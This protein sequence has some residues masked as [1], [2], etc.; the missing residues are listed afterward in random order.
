MIAD[1]VGPWDWQAHP[2]VWFLVAAVVVLGWWAARVIGPKVVPAGTPVTTPF[3]RRAFVAATILLLVSADWPMHD[4]AEDHLYS[5]HML[6]H[7]LITF[8]VPPLFLLAMPGWLA[9][10]LILEDGFGARILRRLT[11]PV[12]AGLIFNGL[13]ALTHWS[14]VVNWSA[15]FGAFHYGVHV[16]LFAA[17]LAM[18]MPVVAPLP[19]LRLSPPGQMLYLFLM[20]IIPTIPAAW[21]TFADGV[22]YPSYD[23]GFELW[24]VSVRSDQQ[25]A[26]LIMKLLGGFYIWGIIVVK[27]F[28]F[29]REQNRQNQRLRPAAGRL[30]DGRSAPV[31]PPQVTEPVE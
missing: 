12:V 22:V 10:L 27:F 14:S 1:V 13:V 7:L 15:E 19:E 21:L 30:P 6:Q 11:H 29:T 23:D 17:A 20:S 9:R 28:S 16:V 5:V 3:Q 8:I 26:G 31:E 18:W 4:I 2:E 24:G 25:T